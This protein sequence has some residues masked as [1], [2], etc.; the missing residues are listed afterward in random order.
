MEKICF[1]SEERAAKERLSQQIIFLQKLVS[2]SYL[3]IGIFENFESLKVFSSE[4]VAQR[5]SVKKVSCN[6]IKNETLAQVL[7][8]EFCEIYKNTFFYRTPLVAASVS[9]MGNP[10]HNFRQS[11]QSTTELFKRTNVAC[12]TCCLPQNFSL[13]S[14]W[15]FY[16]P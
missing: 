5:C 6:F 2:K 11:F 1:Q 12:F 10:N 13:K 8:C 15:T 14:Q 9:S 7:S 16:F 4:A 3:Y